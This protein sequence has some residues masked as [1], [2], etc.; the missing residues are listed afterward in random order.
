MR[1]EILWPLPASLTLSTHFTLP[2]CI[3]ATPSSFLHLKTHPTYS[4]LWASASGVPSAWN[5]LTPHL[6]VDDSLSFSCQHRY[7]LLSKTHLATQPQRITTSVPTLSL[8]DFL[9]LSSDH[10]KPSNVL[11]VYLLVVIGH[12]PARNS[13]MSST[14][15]GTSLLN[16]STILSPVLRTV[17]GS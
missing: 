4:Y 9:H 7:H 16:L 8:F 2:S 5:A 11:F 10:M 6:C 12:A 13:S 14:R 3:P 15:V 1:P 17:P